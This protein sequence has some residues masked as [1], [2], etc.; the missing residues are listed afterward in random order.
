MATNLQQQMANLLKA[1]MEE[2]NAKASKQTATATAT[3]D[4]PANFNPANVNTPANTTAK[5]S[6]ASTFV[7]NGIRYNADGTLYVKAVGIKGISS[8]LERSDR[9]ALKSGVEGDTAAISEQL[10]EAT[11]RNVDG[12]VLDDSQVKALEMLKNSNTACLSGAAGTG[13]TT[14]INQWVNS[15][16]IQEKVIHKGHAIL[17]V[18]FLAFTGKAVSQ[19]KAVL[20]QRYHECCMTIHA[21][22]GYYPEP[23][24]NEKGESTR[25]WVPTY[26]ATNPLNHTL[27]FIDESTMCNVSLWNK[28]REATLPTCR[29]VFIGDINQLPPVGGQPILAH[30]LMHFPHASLE[31]IHR[32]G[33]NSP[34]LR[35]A[36]KILK[37]EAI[38]SETGFA[39]LQLPNNGMNA[40]YKV[41]DL[42]KALYEQGKYD[43]MKDQIITGSND[44]ELGQS[45]LNALISPYINSN[46]SQK[47]FL[48]VTQKHFAIGDKVMYTK[49]D[50]ERN[51]FNGTQGIVTKITP[52]NRCNGVDNLLALVQ[53]SKIDMDIF[54]TSRTEDL[55]KYR[56]S[57]IKGEEVNLEEDG[58]VDGWEASHIVTVAF[59]DGSTHSFNLCSEI[60]ALQL[61]Y[62]CT[63][64]KMQ[65]SECRKVIIICH[66]DNAFIQS[67]EWLYTA[68]TR[69]KESVLIMAS[70]G[71]IART[72]N[73]PRISGQTVDDKIKSFYNLV[74]KTSTDELPIW[75]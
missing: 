12:I 11:R 39:M 72:L 17:N 57:Q 44:N 66:K 18:L 14:V 32:Q 35:N 4:S 52:N 62:V 67:R 54:D 64:H 34:V 13:K 3:A 1:R 51:L 16:N 2:R 69:A 9:H 15:L 43:P 26:T 8:K 56:D 71:S 46:P 29:F 53:P 58:K 38:N 30:A 59:N 65:G 47:V 41:R 33:E 74:Q 61:S 36:H 28:L 24:V 37:G 45:T 42:I 73:S 75:E 60:G 31:K 63:C 20:P 7:R 10:I 55:A 48:K 70:Q 25:V 50:Y 27:I 6:E 23:A 5:S 40:A 19:I 68:V 22:L 21:A 49:N